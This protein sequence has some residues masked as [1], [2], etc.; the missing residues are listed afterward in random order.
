MIA[1]IKMFFAEV[2]AEMKKVSWPTKNEVVYS[3]IVVL[4]STAFLAV[5]VGLAD[6]FL[7]IIV[8]I[9]LRTFSIR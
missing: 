3:T 6:G 8:N 2:S 9:V 7:S 4:I 1:K 5:L